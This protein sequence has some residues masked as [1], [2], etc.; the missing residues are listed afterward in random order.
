MPL[1]AAASEPSPRVALEDAV[2]AVP[3]H[4]L[5]SS[6]AE[7]VR[8]LPLA[9][10]VEVA[11][12]RLRD[13][14]ADGKLHLVA[15]EGAAPEDRVALSFHTMTIAQARAFFVLGPRHSLGRAR[16]LRWAH[17]EWLKT[18]DEPIG[19]VSVGSRTERQP[20]R[21]QLAF[22]QA[23]CRGLGERLSGV[24][25]RLSTLQAIS[26]NLV[27]ASTPSREDAPESVRNTLRPREVAILTLYADGLSAQEIADL[28]VISTHTVRTHIKNAYRRLGVHSRAEAEALI[29]S[30]RVLELV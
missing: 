13:S 9:V 4:D 17:G 26:R 8:K 23:A 30:Q 5:A 27:R 1:V 21:R 7:V 3:G 28:F 20:S 6:L 22:L 29:R 10:G 25:R 18:N 11:S 14:D 15:I 16:G 2:E 24:D 12:I 19:A